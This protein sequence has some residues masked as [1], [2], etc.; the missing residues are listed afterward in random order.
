METKRSGTGQAA[1]LEAAQCDAV[2]ITVDLCFIASEELDRRQELLDGSQRPN[3]TT[4]AGWNWLRRSLRMLNGPRELAD[5]VYASSPRVP[6][7]D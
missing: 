7:M 5:H 3:E 6:H 1:K 4:N 2:D